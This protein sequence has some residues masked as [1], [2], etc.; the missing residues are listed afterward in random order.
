MNS[1]AQHPEPPK[2]CVIHEI[3]D[4][5]LDQQVDVIVNVWNRNIISWWLLLPQ[6]VSGAIKKRAGLAPFWELG[7]HRPIPLGQAVI[8]AAGRLPF[9]AIIHV[10]GINILWRAS[11]SS[12]RNSVTNSVRLADE[13]GFESMAMLLIGSGSGGFS[14]DQARAI[15][16]DQVLEPASQLAV[17]I[18]TFRK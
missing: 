9:K 3:T 11:E 6:G 13:H 12:I 8:T 5:L 17:T 14:T 10:T 1:V 18:V 7:R 4:D 16:A 15:I 2:A